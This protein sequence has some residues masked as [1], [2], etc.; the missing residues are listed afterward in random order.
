MLNSVVRF[1]VLTT[2]FAGCGA[3]RGAV[4]VE[5]EGPLRPDQPTRAIEG[6]PVSVAPANPGAQTERWGQSPMSD[7]LKSYFREAASWDIDR[8]AQAIRRARLAWMVAGAGWI[9]AVAVSVRACPL[10]AAQ[11]GGALRHPRG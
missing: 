1:L 10:D 4:R 7:E 8:T 9:C 11:N 3:H 2:L 6:S 5:C